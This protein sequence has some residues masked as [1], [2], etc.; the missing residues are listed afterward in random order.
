MATVQLHEHG[1]DPEMLADLQHKLADSYKAMPEL[2]YYDVKLF[3]KISCSL[4]ASN[5]SEIIFQ[6]VIYA[7]SYI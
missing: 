2:R 6:L 7:Q 5:V 4:L 1:N 3:L